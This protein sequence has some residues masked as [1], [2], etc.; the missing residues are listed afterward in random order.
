MDT[1]EARKKLLG[2][3][4][5]FRNRDLSITLKKVD[6]ILEPENIYDPRTKDHSCIAIGK[7]ETKN[8]FVSGLDMKVY[9]YLHTEIFKDFTK[10]AG[11]R[12]K[13]T[14]ATTSHAM[15]PI[16]PGY[17]ELHYS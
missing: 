5:H 2:K 12:E 7:M 16:A 6:E 13:Y 15:L 9:I 1:N 3:R 10:I 17:E 4:I 11:D 8:S 14:G